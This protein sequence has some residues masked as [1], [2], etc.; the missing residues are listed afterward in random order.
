MEFYFQI[1]YIFQTFIS[2]SV[3]VILLDI[4][5]N[6][7]TPTIRITITLTDMRSFFIIKKNIL[8]IYNLIAY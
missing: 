2:V 8:F 4:C 5:G 3:T 7:H 6:Y 1:I